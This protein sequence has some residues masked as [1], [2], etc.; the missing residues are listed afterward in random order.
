MAIPKLPVP[1]IRVLDES[2][3]SPIN[4][5]MAQIQN[6]CLVSEVVLPSDLESSAHLHC[7]A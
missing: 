7:S 4:P 2:G 1:L 5:Q 3:K 6:R